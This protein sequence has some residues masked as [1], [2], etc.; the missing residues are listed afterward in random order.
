[1]RS[2]RCI[3]IGVI[4]I[5]AFLSPLWGL[6]PSL[7]LQDYLLD[8]WNVDSGLPANN[9]A[10]LA[11]TPDGYLWIGTY[12]GLARF[13]GV[14]MQ[15]IDSGDKAR[16]LDSTTRSLHAD[17]HGYLWISTFSG[18]T[19]FK[20]NRFRYF[21]EADGLPRDPGFKIYE[22]VNGRILITA[23]A[24]SIYEFEWENEGFK[25]FTTSKN[26]R[27]TRVVTILQDSKGIL[28]FSSFQEGLF[29]LINDRFEKIKF[30]FG[31]K[32]KYH[33]DIV[34][35]RDGTMWMGT[36][37]GLLHMDRDKQVFYTSADCG[38]SRDRP[39]D[40]LEDNDGN[41]WVSTKAGVN[42][43]TVDKDG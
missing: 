13:D 37:K 3:V 29:K 10:C 26:F 1:M 21:G 41:L 28:W 4:V 36:D 40:I 2:G 14:K 20:D 38:L 35:S 19:R 8:E 24:D 6:D 33:L 22:D 16:T 43:M 23:R 34:E 39:V 12:A 5:C 15:R 31:G 18:L 30:N 27:G 11:Q 17:R 32:F 25:K 42:R 7:P 9:V